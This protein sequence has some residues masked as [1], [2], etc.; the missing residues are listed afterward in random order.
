MSGF[1]FCSSCGSELNEG[2]EYCSQCGVKQIAHG[3]R[4]EYQGRFSYSGFW[5]R[6]IA[7]LIDA[8]I[9]GIVFGILNMGLS[10]SG[11]KLLSFLG[12]WFYFA[13]LESSTH[14]A[15]LGKML[16]GAK[17]VDY[18][19]NRI[20][21]VTA[22]L[23]H[24]AKILSAIILLIGFIMVGFTQKKQ[25]LHDILAGTLVIRKS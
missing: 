8:I 1:K 18:G 25:G 22:S 2:E 6:F 23:R 5:R 9:L 16:I 4:V 14:Q 24:F 11:A 21:F 10:E 15:T 3:M 13:Y 12:G 19:G 17:V 20:S 7:Y